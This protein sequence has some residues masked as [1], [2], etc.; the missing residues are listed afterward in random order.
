VTFAASS[1]QV[2]KDFHERAGNNFMSVKDQM[3]DKL[4]KALA[5]TQLIVT[6]DSH[7]HAGHMEHPGG[8]A[9]RGETHF[10]IKIVAQSFS[11]QSRIARH[12]RI[13]ELLQ[14]ELST[15]VHALAIDAKAPEDIN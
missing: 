14:A 3:T 12:R 15:G 6:D 1:P 9:P 13:H 7:H 4:T 8:V 5:P 10:S 2:R 11:G